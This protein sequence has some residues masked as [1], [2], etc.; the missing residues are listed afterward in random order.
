MKTKPT[1]TD[2]GNLKL[3]REPTANSA[4]TEPEFPR[5]RYLSR[6]ILSWLLKKPSQ[7][8]AYD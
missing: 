1:G 6:P 4:D 2:T 3:V 7:C 5:N 8:V